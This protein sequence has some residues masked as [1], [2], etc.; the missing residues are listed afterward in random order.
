MAGNSAFELVNERGW[1]RG[2][3]NLL[4]NELGHWW[5]TRR[6]WTQC[7]IWGA[8]VGFMMAAVVFGDASFQ[9]TD[10]VMLYSI[11]AGLFPA[12]GV[13]ILMQGAL[14][15]EK[16][17]GTAAWVLSK[18]ASRAAFIVSKLVANSL[19]VLATMVLVPGVV[20]FIILSYSQKALLDPLPFLAA[21]AIF[22]LNHFFYLTLTLML[23]ALFSNRGAVIGIGLALLFLQQYLVGLLPFLVYLL[24]WTLAVP[25]ND[26]T[27][28]VAPALLQ[29]QAVYSWIPVAA[30]LVE[31]ILFVVIALR[32]F[33]REEF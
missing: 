33:E 3:N 14:V 30:V 7:L 2:L 9:F 28:A 32:R 23:G 17:D 6:W 11:F 29:G 27:A 24:P 16:Q 5:R 8:I 1:R 19:G 21:W 12:V 15:G 25:L 10:G 22:F 31:S 20:A 18:P 26:Q 13:V 4:D